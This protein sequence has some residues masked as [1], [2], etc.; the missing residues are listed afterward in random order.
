VFAPVFLNIS[1]DRILVV[2]SPLIP[3]A[4]LSN[5]N[6]LESA[7][8]VWLIILLLVVALVSTAIVPSSNATKLR[9]PVPCK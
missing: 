3:K 9:V 7:V 6:I 5:E 1:N 4:V 2:K 8:T